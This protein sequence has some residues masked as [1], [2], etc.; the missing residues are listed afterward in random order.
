M[1]DGL[2]MSEAVTATTVAATIWLTAR[3]FRLR[4]PG[5]FAWAG[6]AA[7]LAALARAELVLILPVVAVG[8]LVQRSRPSPRPRWQLA[9]VLLLAGT[10]VMA[11]WVVRNLVTFERPV[12]LSDGWDL[13]AVGANCPTTY[14]GA[15]IG[16]NDL[17]CGN[18]VPSGSDQSVA[19]AKARSIGVRYAT[20]HVDRWPAVAFARLGRTFAFFN[21]GQ[22]IDLDHE[23][24][25]RER[26]LSTAGVVVWW[27]SVAI[28]AYGLVALRRRRVSILPLLA[29]L[30]AVALGVVVTY[31]NTRLRVPADVAMLVAA[32]IGVDAWRDRRRAGLRA[33]PDPEPTGSS[34]RQ[35]A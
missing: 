1:T 6:G 2:I 22:Q 35:T 7:G 25:R 4:T 5:A 12:L 30:G 13:T 31:G 32:A 17:R 18:R 15:L 9:G 16:V 19:F 10:L 34:T 21:V 33:Q 23:F 3:A 20:H 11:P 8:A 24:E 14:S 29:P 27:A 28:G 26:A